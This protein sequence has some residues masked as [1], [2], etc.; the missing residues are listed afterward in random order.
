MFACSS[1][2]AMRLVI[3]ALEMPDPTTPYLFIKFIAIVL[4]SVALFINAIFL[5]ATMGDTVKYQAYK[6]R[7]LDN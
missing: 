2:L 3:V 7:R 5:V 4:I 1:A 6:M